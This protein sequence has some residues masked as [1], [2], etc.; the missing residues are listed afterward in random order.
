MTVRGLKH[1]MF[2]AA[3]IRTLICHVNIAVTLCHLCVVL[4]EKNTS[5]YFCNFTSRSLN[6]EVILLQPLNY[7]LVT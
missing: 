1:S 2:T 6:D 7:L 4:M 5:N 3:L